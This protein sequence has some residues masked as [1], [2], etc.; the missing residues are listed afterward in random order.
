VVLLDLHLPGLSG[1]EGVARLHT[2]GLAILVLSA[3]N[4]PP[5]VLDAIAAG[6]AG[7]LT[8]NADGTEIIIAV[9]T[10]ATGG[11]YISPTLASFLLAASHS[12]P[13]GPAPAPGPEYAGAGTPSDTGGHPDAA[14]LTERERAILGLVAAGETDRDIA[15][16]LCISVSTVRSHL[17][18]IRHKTGRRRRPD[19][20]RLAYQ[21][22]LAPEEYLKKG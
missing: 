9:R 3:I 14:G 10:I 6:A 20:T 1:A 8:K 7:Y 13:P 5:E 17:D 18:R 19:L 15:A 22:G 12:A 11:T 21:V 4:D 2:A 16:A